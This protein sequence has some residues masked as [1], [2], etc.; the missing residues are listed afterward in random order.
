MRKGHVD[1]ELA[2]SGP[3]NARYDTIYEM[4]SD[5]DWVGSQA[6]DVVL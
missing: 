5:V 3:D 1:R 2:F 4:R 6:L